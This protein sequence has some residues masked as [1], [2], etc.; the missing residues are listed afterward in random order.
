MSGKPASGPGL[1][2]TMSWLH[3]WCGLVCGWLLCAIFLTGSISVFRESIT[4]WMQG[5]PLEGSGQQALSPQERLQALRLAEQHLSKTAP[6]ASI[7]RIGLPLHTGDG[8]KVFARAQDGDLQASL[9]VQ[10][11]EVLPEPAMRQTEGGRH[12]MSFHYSLQGGIAGFWVVGLVSMCMLVAL[13]S[14]VIV[15]RRIFQDFFTFRPGKGQR[16]WLDAHNASAVLTLP[17]LFMIV[18]TGLAHFYTSYMPWPLQSLYGQDRSAYSRYE[19]ELNARSEANTPSNA[20]A[21]AVVDLVSLAQQAQSLLT[22]PVVGVVVQRPEGAPATIR[23]TEGKPDTAVTR[24]MVNSA[25]SVTFDAVDGELLQLSANSPSSSFASDTYPVI[26]ALHLVTFGG[27]AMKWLYFVL[28][29][30]GTAMI[31]SGSILFA[32]KRRAR[33]GHEWGAATPSM[34]R[35]ID[36]LNV[37]A[38]AGSALASIAYLYG[39]RLL[40]LVLEARSSWEIRVFFAVWVL[41]L[42]HALLRTARQA[43]CEQLWMLALLCLGLPLLNVMTTGQHLLLY[44]AQ[45]DGQRA[46]LELTCMA[47][48]L[49]VAWGAWRHEK[50]QRSKNM[51][52]LRAGRGVVSGGLT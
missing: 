4:L 22:E 43:W 35:C 28:G 32:V 23:F 36:A 2:Q 48:G 52:Q 10:T 46:G 6:D 16:S 42:L 25:N 11:G 21:I 34:Y 13:V 31:A 30:V 1:R 38:L 14:G 9:D 26:S 45:G 44:L 51:A 12:F 8:V 41:S 3:T 33:S 29:L 15:H 7:W 37:A 5:L 20:P 50:S 40:P 47:L 19:S 27:W 49:L 39:N 17:F 24:R 18:Y